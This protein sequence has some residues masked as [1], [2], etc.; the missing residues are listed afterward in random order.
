[1]PSRLS[2]CQVQSSGLSGLQHLSS[3]FSIPS[4]RALVPCPPCQC[5]AAATVTA[6]QKSKF[7][8]SNWSHGL[9]CLRQFSQTS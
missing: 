9:S 1:M 2:P 8:R 4:G 5:V 3:A 6:R 7:G